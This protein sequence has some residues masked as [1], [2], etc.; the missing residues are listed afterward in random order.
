MVTDPVADFVNQLKN[1]GA[2][3]KVTV[4]VPFSNLKFAIANVLQSKGY[5]K[6]VEEKGKK[7]KRTLE[8]TLSYADTGNHKISGVKRVSKPGRRMYKSVKE[9]FPVRYGHGLVLLST[10]KGVMAGD[11]AKKAGVGGEVLFEIW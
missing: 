7:T 2:V 3:G 9:I 6:Q 11:E 1:A 10:P 5:I 8:V 4:A